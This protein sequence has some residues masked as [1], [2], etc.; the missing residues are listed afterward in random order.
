MWGIP[1]REE[2]VIEQTLE[3]IRI[4]GFSLGGE[5]TVLAAPEFNVCFDVGRA[6]REIIAID[7][8]LLSHGHM[9]HAAGVAYYFSQRTFV[10]VHPGRVIVH[11]SIAQAI[12][13]LMDVWS[14]IE[15]HPSPGQVWGIE[16]LQEVEIRRG[17]CARAFT[18]NHCPSSLG[19]SLIEKRH[20]LK[21]EFTG[22]DGPQ[23]VA[24][25]RQGVNIEE[26]VEIP[27]LTYTGDTAIGR[28]MDIDFVRESK[29]ILLECTFFEREH[30]ERA[31]A[32][33]HIHV[34]DLP[35]ILEALSNPRIMLVHNTRRTDFRTCKRIV[36]RVIKPAD[37]ER[38]SMFMDR[39]TRRAETEA[40]TPSEVE[41]RDGE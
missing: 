5:E 6:P 29:A 10:G 18:V 20:K 21:S 23:L 38:V 41:S 11:L 32:G 15:R 31:R 22:L 12:Q 27:L 16:H 30:R 8:I 3:G 33:R 13:K 28:W 34:D 1:Y 7:N 26:K 40:V 19:Y 9:D 14:E 35:K 37:R 17:L 25:K 4:V 2:P 39:G 36:E 24:L